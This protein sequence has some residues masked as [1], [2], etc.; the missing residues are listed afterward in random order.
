M[1]G[2]QFCRDILL[3]RGNAVQGFHMGCV[4]KAFSVRLLCQGPDQCWIFEQREWP[5]LLGARHLTG[6]QLQILRRHTQPQT[7]P[8]RLWTARLQCQLETEGAPQGHQCQNACRCRWAIKDCVVGWAWHRQERHT[9]THT[10]HWQPGCAVSSCLYHAAPHWCR[11]ASRPQHGTK[12]GHV[13]SVGGILGDQIFQVTGLDGDGGVMS[14]SLFVFLRWDASWNSH[15]KD[16]MASV[17][18]V[19]PF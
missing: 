13:S 15:I 3:V 8:A 4:W 10:V 5:T 6:R 12:T 11:L 1:S 2:L 9:H 16:D 19:G 7:S 17:S 18:P 14:I